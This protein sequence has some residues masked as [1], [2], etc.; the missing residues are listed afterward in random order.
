MSRFC[1]LSVVCWF[2]F[3]KKI[4]EEYQKRVEHLRTRSG[5]TYCWAW[6]VRNLFSKVISC[7]QK[8]PFIRSNYM[9]VLLLFCC[10]SHTRIQKVL[11]EG[12]NYDKVFSGYWG[13][14]GSKYHLKRAIIGPPAKRHLNL[15]PPP[16]SGSAHASV[17]VDSMLTVVLL[18]P[19]CVR[20]WPLFLCSI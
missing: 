13:E 16:P 1:L 14:I 9:V 10:C 8:S 5:S 20:G 17:V 3:Q 7:P 19:L 18:L 15:A 2:H 6:S 12:S 4:C 11:S